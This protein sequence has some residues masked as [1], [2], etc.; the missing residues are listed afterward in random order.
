MLA[1]QDNWVSLSSSDD[2][3]FSIEHQ[4]LHPDKTVTQQEALKVIF[5]KV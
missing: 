3:T 5:G 1:H 4:S 2:T